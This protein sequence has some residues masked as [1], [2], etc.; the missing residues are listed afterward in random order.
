[1]FLCSLQIVQLMED[2]DSLVAQQEN[3]PSGAESAPQRALQ[4]KGNVMN[5]IL[6]YA[7]EAILS[8]EDIRSMDEATFVA[9]LHDSDEAKL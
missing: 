5:R 9:S 3:K 7:N 4:M 1:M 6:K 2:K 8:P